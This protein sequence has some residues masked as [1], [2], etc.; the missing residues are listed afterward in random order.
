M[1]TAIFTGTFNPFTIGHADIVER[2]LNIFDKVVIGIGYNPAKEGT[3]SVEERVE[4]IK[5]VYDGNGRVEVEAYM[6]MAADLAA[7]HNAVAVVKGVRSVADY[8]Y[9]R[10]QAEYNRLLGD[11]LETV[12]FFS[13]PELSALSSSGV[14]TLQMFGKDTSKF[15]P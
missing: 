15:L 4:Q 2:A 1:R 7:R 8:E 5:S 9:E 10:N 11:G 12:L 14:R 3:A 13:R 6:D